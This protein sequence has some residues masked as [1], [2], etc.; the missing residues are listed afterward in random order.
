MIKNLQK[1][2]KIGNVMIICLVTNQL[3]FIIEV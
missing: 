3:Q 2:R 1:E